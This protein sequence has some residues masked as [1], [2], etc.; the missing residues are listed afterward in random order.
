MPS[1]SKKTLRELVV[2]VLPGVDEQLLV[3]LAQRR[4]T[5]AAFTNWGRFPTIVTIRAEFMYST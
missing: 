3:R 5:A 4:D 2:V 1:S